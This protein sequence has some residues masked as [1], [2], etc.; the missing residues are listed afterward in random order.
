MGV[1]IHLQLERL[2]PVV[3]PP[4]LRPGQKE[5]LLRGEAVDLVDRILGQRFLERVLDPD[6]DRRELVTLL[7]LAIALGSLAVS[8]GQLA[9]N[10]IRP[11]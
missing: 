10:G 9:F 3:A 6:D 11:G 5:P 1:G 8:G 7:V 4:R 2:G